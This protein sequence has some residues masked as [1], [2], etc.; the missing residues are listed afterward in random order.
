MDKRLLRIRAGAISV[1]IVAGI[2]LLFGPLI[3]KAWTWVTRARSA[4]WWGA[5]GQWAGAAGTVAAVV[6]ALWIARRDGRIAREDRRR[7]EL[8]DRQEQASRVTAWIEV[9]ENGANFPDG[10]PVDLYMIVAN[11]NPE[12][13][14][15]VMVS[16]D[17]FKGLPVYGPYIQRGDSVEE[18]EYLYAVLPPGKW[19]M[20][21]RP[22]WAGM[23]AQPG[24]MLAFTDSKNCHWLRLTDGTLTEQPENVIKRREIWFP[25]RI[26]VPE[27][28]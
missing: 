15:Y 19:R 28:Y 2:I 22:G 21:V 14:N 8:R 3:V 24:V 20:P 16:F 11:G 23:S 9:P 5:V 4:D 13:I 12:A 6:V 18:D 25:Q 10:A 17:I 26:S 27:S 7:Q 1:L